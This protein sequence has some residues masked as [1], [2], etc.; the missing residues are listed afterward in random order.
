MAQT[1]IIQMQD[2]LGGGKESRMNTPGRTEGNWQWRLPPSSDLT[3][4]AARLADMT[5]RYDRAR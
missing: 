2:L 5:V 1:A 4:I 3:E